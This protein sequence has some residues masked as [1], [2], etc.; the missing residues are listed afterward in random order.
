MLN[1]N[2]YPVLVARFLFEMLRQSQSNLS[3]T[4]LTIYQ[5]YNGRSV[6]FELNVNIGRPSLRSETTIQPG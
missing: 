5:L 3:D 6:L 2:S 4:A 1:K